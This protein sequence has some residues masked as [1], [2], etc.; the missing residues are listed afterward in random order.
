MELLV[1]QIML[2]KETFFNVKIFFN[3]FFIF[4]NILIQMQKLKEKII[5]N[6][7]IQKI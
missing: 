3:I 1:K 7:K 4:F 6:L 2:V 5:Q